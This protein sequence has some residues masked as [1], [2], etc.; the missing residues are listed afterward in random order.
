MS[1]LAVVFHRD[2]QP[3]AP[4]LVREM[5][6]SADYLGPDRQQVMTSGALALGFAALDL[7]PEECG[8]EQPLVSPRTGCIVLADV[9]LDNRDELFATLPERIAKTASDAEL[10]LRG[11]EVWG[12]D[13]LPRLLGDFAFVIWDPREERLF[14]ARD[15]SAQRPLYYRFDQRTIVLASAIQSLF[16]DPAVPIEPNEERIFNYLVPFH[17]LRNEAD[18]ENTFFAGVY[19]LPGGHALLVNRQERRVWRYWELQPPAELRYRDPSEYVE[20]FVELFSRSVRARLRCAGPVGALLSGGMDSSSVVCVAQEVFRA[21]QAV[22][23]GFT[24]FSSVFDG[25]PCDERHLIQTIPEKY[26]FAAQYIPVVGKVACFEPN[27]PGFMRGPGKNPSELDPVYAATTKS[28]VRV[29]LSGDVADACVFGSPLVFDSLLASGQIARLW[30][31]ARLYHQQNSESWRKIVLWHTLVPLLPLALQRELWVRYVRRAFTW[32][33]ESLLP[34]WMPPNLREELLSRHLAASID[35]ARHRRFRSPPRQAES[36]WLYPPEVG[37]DTTGW[38]IQIWRPYA[39]R[40]LHE[41]L[42]AIPPEEKFEPRAD[43]GEYYAGAKQ[44]IRRGLDGV[45]PDAVRNQAHKSHFA[46]LV[47]DE[48][49]RRWDIYAETFG[50]GG[51]SHCAARGLIDSGR[52]WWRLN[53]LRE[54]FWGT[55]FLQVVHTF[56]LET[57][58]RTFDLP[59]TQRAHAAVSASVLGDHVPYAGRTGSGL[60]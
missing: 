40:R 11:Y 2:G 33:R 23:H 10:I 46:W 7:T 24:S 9:R 25:L 15:T 60:H 12:L 6:A 21:G 28:G 53:R 56:F 58:L 4:T 29:L 42:L 30:Q 55:D 52:F 43:V 59:R 48:V 57:W 5:L 32:E 8:E 54:G 18:G 17:A 38:P 50:P 37:H 47:E 1:G 44:L 45:M 16:Q 35:A 51:S 27:P 20:H 31:R 26:G 19:A 34:T 14:A 36:D 49:N 22:D 41:Y 13:V 3:A 39:D